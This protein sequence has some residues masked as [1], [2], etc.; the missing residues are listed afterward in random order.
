MQLDRFLADEGA[1]ERTNDAVKARSS[2]KP[3]MISMSLSL[4]KALIPSITPLGGMTTTLAAWFFKEK[5][6]KATWA[7]PVL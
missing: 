4:R 7:V 2:S 3:L 1:V 5:G 6:S